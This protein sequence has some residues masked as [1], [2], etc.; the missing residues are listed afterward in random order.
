MNLGPES[1]SIDST[2]NAERRHPATIVSW[3]ALAI[4]ILIAGFVVRDTISPGDLRPGGD[5]TA[6]LPQIGEPAPDFEAVNAEGDM[7]RLSDFDGSPVWLNF[8]GS[9][10]PPCRAEAPDMI[11]AYDQLE[12]RGVALLAVS[13]EEPSEDAFEYADDVGMN[14]TVLSDPDREAIRGKYRVRSFPTHLF[15]DEDGIVRDIVLTP[16]PVGTALHHAGKI[17]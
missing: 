5:D 17:S 14:F 8:W 16:M 7:V 3:I 11:Q 13:L 9:W 6:G 10:C 4:A 1:T 2:P 12:P 15:I